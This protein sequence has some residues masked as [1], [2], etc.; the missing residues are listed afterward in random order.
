MSTFYIVRHGQSIANSQKIMQ[1]A[2][3]DTPLTTTGQAQAHKTA[4]KLSQHNF[5]Q[6]F[7]S[8]LLRAA[9]TAQII[10]PKATITYDW[11]LR[12][13]DYG[14]WDGQKTTQLWREYAQ[15]FD[16]NHNLLPGSQE[17]SH[18][19]THSQAKARLLSFFDETT[20]KLPQDAQVLLVSHGYT[21]KL[22]VDIILDIDNLTALNEP[23]N[24]GITR[25]E[26]TSQSHTLK[27]FNR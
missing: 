15:F 26:W 6:V 7:A 1:G 9:Q 16:K 25:I 3:I 22:I 2:M 11:R 20:Q 24:V 23:T 17:Y 27:Y 12:E 5:T 18:G 21:I 10:V 13:F 8:P 19:E 4:A 14:L